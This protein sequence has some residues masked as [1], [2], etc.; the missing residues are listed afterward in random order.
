[1]RMS[2]NKETD[3]S[4]AWNRCPKCN[5]IVGVDE[6]VDGSE[7]DCGAC[8]ERLV[9]TEFVDDTWALISADE[10]DADESEYEQGADDVGGGP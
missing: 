8:D 9:C 4:C 10:G 3:T 1:M 5:E 7:V 6:C 2:E